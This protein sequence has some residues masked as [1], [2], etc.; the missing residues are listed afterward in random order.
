MLPFCRVAGVSPFEAR[1]AGGVPRCVG[2]R[3]V[4]A[5]AL[6]D[7]LILLFFLIFFARFK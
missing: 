4:P 5:P 2:A 1:G 7:S 3:G 6:P